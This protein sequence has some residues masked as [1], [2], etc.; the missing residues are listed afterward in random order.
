MRC[1]CFFLLQHSTASRAA[2]HMWDRQCAVDRPASATDSDRKALSHK[3]TFASRSPSR[4]TDMSPSQ[5]ALDISGVGVSHLLSTCG[6]FSFVFAYPCLLLRYFFRCAHP[7]H[8]VLT[9]FTPTPF[10]TQGTHTVC[11]CRA[12]LTCGGRRTTSVQPRRP[13]QLADDQAGASAEQRSALPAPQQL[14]RRPHPRA[15]MPRPVAVPHPAHATMYH[16]QLCLHRGM[17]VP[18]RPATATPGRSHRRP[19]RPTTV[20]PPLWA[21]CSPVGPPHL[22]LP[23]PW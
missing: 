12:G 3:C 7:P 19:L 2:S 14:H 1:L 22:S 23:H 21:T 15:L 11:Q 6:V 13:R 17:V 10:H 18:R 4:L 8:V 9:L 16:C 20:Q 5:F